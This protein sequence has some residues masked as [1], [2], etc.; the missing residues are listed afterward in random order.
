[1][2]A[3]HSFIKKK[4]FVIFSY[5]NINRSFEVRLV[6]VINIRQNMCNGLL[7]T[8]WMPPLQVYSITNLNFHGRGGFLSSVS[9]RST[10]EFVHIMMQNLVNNEM[11]PSHPRFLRR[12]SVTLVNINRGQCSLSFGI[13][14]I[15]EVTD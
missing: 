14:M 8:V 11:P 2:C 1:M 9:R 5:V 6:D 10:S 12:P 4:I 7:P 13:L 3:C 15:T